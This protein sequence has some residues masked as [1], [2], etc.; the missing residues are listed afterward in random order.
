MCFQM[1]PKLSIAGDLS[2]SIAGK[3]FHTRA[4]LRQQNFCRRE[5]YVCVEQRV[6]CRKMSGDNDD[7]AQR[8]AECRQIGTSVLLTYAIGV[9]DMQ[10]RTPDDLSVEPE[11]RYCK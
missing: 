1:L 5:W 10:P 8:R 4:V 11:T 2:Y 7:R 6:F 3:L 9:P